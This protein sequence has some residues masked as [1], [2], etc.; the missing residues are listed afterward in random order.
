MD[1][2]TKSK[3]KRIDHRCEADDLHPELLATADEMN[4][5]VRVGFWPIA[6]HSVYHGMSATGENGRS[7]FPFQRE[8]GSDSRWRP[9]GGTSTSP[10]APPLPGHSLPINCCARKHVKIRILLNAGQLKGNCQR[11][12]SFIIPRPRLTPPPAS[13]ASHT[14]STVL[15]LD[16]GGRARTTKV[17]AAPKIMACMAH[18]KSWSSGYRP[19]SPRR[20]SSRCRRW[21]EYHADAPATAPRAPQALG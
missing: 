19:L 9:A 13:S 20:H 18:Q 21:L 17:V 14:A 10:L 5:I 12:I 3:A 11:Q 8:P 6:A 16:P 2:P 1:P 4:R 15:A 7:L